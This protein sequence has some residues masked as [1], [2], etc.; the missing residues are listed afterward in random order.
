[1]FL[2]NATE[3]IMLGYLETLDFEDISRYI[4][5]CFDEKPEKAKLFFQLN[6]T[7]HIFIHPIPEFVWEKTTYVSS[8]HVPFADCDSSWSGRIEFEKE[9]TMLELIEEIYIYYNIKKVN[10][11][12]NA[13]L[14]KYEPFITD[15]VNYRI[16]AMRNSI[17]FEGFRRKGDDLVLSY[18]S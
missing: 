7:E 5:W 14:E 13:Y 16:E 11:K 4:S 8:I 3:Q 1:M 17:F 2:N 12:Y 6:S 9:Q 18:G 15:P 10:K